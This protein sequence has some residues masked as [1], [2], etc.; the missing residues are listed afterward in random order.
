MRGKEVGI[1]LGSE[2][3]YQV[4]FALTY[5]ADCMRMLLIMFRTGRWGAV[6]F[7]LIA[8]GLLYPQAVGLSTSGGGARGLITV[9]MIG[10]GT[11]EDP[12]RPAYVTEA[13][14]PFQYQLSDDGATAL[15]LVSGE[16]A[17]ELSKLEKSLKTDTRVRVFLP[18]RDKK[19][20]MVNEL[21]KLK[22]DFDPDS[23]AEPIPVAPQQPGAAK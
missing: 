4:L 20:D 15:V 14:I 5:F 21:K 12:K 13:R 6:C 18:G 19:A 7:L 17:A 22:K 9:P 1:F 23:F 3:A 8:N 11:W 10:S 2:F 16:N